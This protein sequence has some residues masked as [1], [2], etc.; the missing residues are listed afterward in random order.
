MQL[1]KNTGVEKKIYTASQEKPLS[2]QRGD[3]SEVLRNLKKTLIAQI[4]Y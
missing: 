3:S 1:E 4:L 2:E